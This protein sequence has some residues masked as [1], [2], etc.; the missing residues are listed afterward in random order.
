MVPTLRQ[1]AWLRR[2]I[3]LDLERGAVYNSQALVRRCIEVVITSSTRNR[4]GGDEPSRG[5]ESHRL[6]H[7]AGAKPAL[8]RRLFMP[9]AQ[10]TPSARF[11]SV[12]AQ[13]KTPLGSL[14]QKNAKIAVLCCNFFIFPARIHVCSG[15]K[16]RTSPVSFRFSEIPSHIEDFFAERIDSGACRH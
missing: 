1:A 4:V 2:K 14:Y 7:A 9:A 5:F 13:G 8:L 12:S 15:M 6:R 3:F 10:K 16:R 11:G